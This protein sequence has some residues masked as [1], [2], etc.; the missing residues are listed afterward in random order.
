[1]TLR[2]LNA[3]AI[4]FVV[5][6]SALNTIPLQAQQAGT[7]QPN[8]SAGGVGELQKAVQNPIA[9]LISVPVQNNSNFGIGPFD[10][11]QN[12]LNIQ[13]VIPIG[14][15]DNWNLIIRW[16]TPILWQPAPGTANLEVFGIE[17]DTPP[18]FAAQAVQKSV[19]IFGLG[20]MTPSFF[21]S[22]SKP[23]K[24][25]WGVGPVFVLPTATSKVLGQGKL[26]IGPSIVALVQPGKWTLG[27]LVNNVWSV[28]GPS[29]RH[30]VNQMSWQYF[31]N[32]NLKRGWYLSSSPIVTANWQA[33]GGNVWTVPVGGGMG[34]V[35]RLG[36]QPVNVAAQLYGNAAHPRNG[37]SWSMRLQIAFL[38][39]K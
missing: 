39:P 7:A 12:V 6:I 38:F 35:F 13:P 22:P 23:G 33:A 17:E 31:V 26:S 28:A 5:W 34:R 10:R 14:A 3:T 9:S 15:S 29:D 19:G 32:Y 30:D 18:Y 2:Q 25:I 16:I 37:S 1:M 27:A 21:L 4:A 8:P 11:T 24:L 36:L 20:D